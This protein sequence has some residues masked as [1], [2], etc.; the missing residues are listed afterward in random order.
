MNFFSFLLKLT[1]IFTLNLN[2]FYSLNFVSCSSEINSAKEEKELKPGDDDYTSAAASV[3]IENSQYQ[4]KYQLKMANTKSNS[5]GKSEDQDF[6]FNYRTLE[7]HERNLINLKKVLDEIET[8][9]MLK[10]IC[11]LMYMHFYNTYI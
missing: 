9:T 5:D 8:R 3:P 6:F 10:L 11:M 7:D 1:L 4:Y 2:F